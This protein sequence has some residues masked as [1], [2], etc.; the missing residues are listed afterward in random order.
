MTVDSAAG[1]KFALFGPKTAQ[2]PRSCKTE[3]GILKYC[4]RIGMVFGN[5]MG[6]ESGTRSCDL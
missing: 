5:T 3:I 2:Y 4:A 1:R 6:R